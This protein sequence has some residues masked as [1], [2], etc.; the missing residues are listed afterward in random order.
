MSLYI[1][2]GPLGNLGDISYRAVEVLAQVDVVACE[3][4]RRTVKLL[5]HYG[6]KKRLISL[7][8]QNEQASA[9]GIVKLLESGQEAAY[10]SDAGTPAVSDPARILVRTARDAGFDVV[11]LPGPS[12]FT[13]L[14]SVAGIPGEYETGDLMFAGFLSPREGR[15]K[16][17]LAALLETGNAFLLFES[18]YRIVKLIRNLADLDDM[19]WLCIGREMTKIHEEYIEGPVHK[20]AESFAGEF[21]EKGEFSL[22]VSGPK[23]S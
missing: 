11:P 18:P 22:L 8:A 12:A 5:N 9:A 10:I 16:K 19:R 7:R 20:I 14:V 23:K 17:R 13:A 21:K 2:A 3:D 15:R 1:V 4:T 6:I